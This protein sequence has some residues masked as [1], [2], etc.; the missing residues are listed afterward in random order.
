MKSS[1]SRLGIRQLVIGNFLA[2][3]MLLTGCSKP[4]SAYYSTHPE[5]LVKAMQLC[6]NSNNNVKQC[7][8]LRQVAL[9]I[10]AYMNELRNNPQLF[11][12]EIIKLQSKL[13]TSA[14]L[15]TSERSALTKELEQRMAVVRWLETPGG[16]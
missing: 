8:D 7:N 5:A 1:W 12:Q 4:N 14:S 3:I 15:A 13:A 16:V 6:S 11:G 10:N 2:I 9:E